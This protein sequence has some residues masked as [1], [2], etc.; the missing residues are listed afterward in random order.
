MDS[1]RD[2]ANKIIISW[3]NKKQRRMRRWRMMAMVMGCV[4]G[5]SG[6]KLMV[7]F[8]QQ[9]SGYMDKYYT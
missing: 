7:Y 6:G 9:G 5:K 1:K 3:G 4:G 8:T 2:E